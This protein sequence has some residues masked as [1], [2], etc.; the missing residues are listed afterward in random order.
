MMSINGNDL[1]RRAFVIGGVGVAGGLMVGCGSGS[2]KP[3]STT[4]VSDAVTWA[5]TNLPKLTPD[6]IQAAA[7]EGTVNLQLLL[8]GED[9]YKKF[10]KAFNKRFPFIKVQYNLQDQTDLEKKFAAEQSAKK[11]VGDVFTLGGPDEMPEFIKKGMIL[12]HEISEDSAFPAGA[13]QTGYWYAFH[14]QFGVTAYRAGELKPNELQLAKTWQGLG[15]PSFKGRLGIHDA[16]NGLYRAQMYYIQYHMDPSAWPRLAAN[17]AVVY[18]AIANGIDQL[19]GG[20]FDLLTTGSIASVNTAAKGGA[21]IEFIETGPSVSNYPPQAISSLAPNPNAA[22]V[23]LD[24]SM[25]KEGQSLWPTVSGV[26]SARHD[27]TAKTWYQQKSWYHNADEQIDQI[28]WTDLA[29][30]SDTVI[31]RFD[32][33]FK[34]N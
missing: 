4:S 21:P 1:S 29:A 15:D 6:V 5:S 24:W 11:G 19:L 13:K 14:R 28:D 10:F 7:K 30:K 27:L 25:S 26:P 12:K 20:D 8:Y 34:K 33:A 31:G 2:P 22:K 9:A 23:W 32:S 18:A 17:G 3:G 16:Q